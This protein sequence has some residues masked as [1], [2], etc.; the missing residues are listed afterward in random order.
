MKMHLFLFG[1]GLKWCGGELDGVTTADTSGN[2][3]GNLLVVTCSRH[4]HVVFIDTRQVG[5]VSTIVW[6]TEVQFPEL[7]RGYSGYVRPN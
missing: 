1:R 6:R 3:D 4:C 5:C 2:E 7:P